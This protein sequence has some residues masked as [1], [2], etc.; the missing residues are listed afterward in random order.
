MI[1]VI[2]T[3]LVFPS[4]GPNFRHAP[5]LSPDLHA[6]GPDLPFLR[7]LILENLSL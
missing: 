4:A 7:T 6:L 2:K 5:A 3:A 1:K